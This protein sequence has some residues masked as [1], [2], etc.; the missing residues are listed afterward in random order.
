MQEGEKEKLYTLC[1]EFGVTELFEGLVEKQVTVTRLR[2][3]DENDIEVLLPAHGAR[4]TFKKRWKDWIAGAASVAED[5]LLEQRRAA[6]PSTWTPIHVE[7]ILECAEG[8]RVK[9]Y[10]SQKGSLDDRHRDI[11]IRIIIQYARDHNVEL[12]CKIM[13]T[14]SMEIEDIF[15]NEKKERYYQPKGHTRKS[16][17]GLLYC[18]FSNWKRAQK[19]KRTGDNSTQ[20]MV[21]DLQNLEEESGED[22]CSLKEILKTAVSEEIFSENTLDFWDKTFPLRQHDLCNGALDDIV[23]EWPLYAHKNGKFLIAGDFDKLYPE[24]QSL[25]N[26][27]ETFFDQIAPILKRF[28]KDPTSKKA[29]RDILDYGTDDANSKQNALFLLLHAVLKPHVVFHKK[30]QMKTMRSKPTIADSQSCMLIDLQENNED[31]ENHLKMRQKALD[32][33]N[34]TFHPIIYRLEPSSYRVYCMRYLNFEVDTL[35][36]AVDL[37]FKAYHV[38]HKGQYALECEDVWYFIRIYFYGLELETDKE[39]FAGRINDFLQD[40][41]NSIDNS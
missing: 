3:A 9:K 8:S 37:A 10:Y 33:T 25:H 36:Q 21:E 29:L 1:C 7:D 16:Y 34:R 28:I 24:S 18:K 17:G 35:E 6:R 14:V 30:L 22:L 32:D 2:E 41:N 31:L 5:F 38:M 12:T 40:V 26:K 20:R 19:R 39:K 23:N 13:K 4:I 27:W 15:P 11:L